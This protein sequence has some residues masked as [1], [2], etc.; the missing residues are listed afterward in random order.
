MLTVDIGKVVS[1]ETELLEGNYVMVVT[2]ILCDSVL[3]ISGLRLSFS[4]GVAYMTAFTVVV[5][6]K[7]GI[8]FGMPI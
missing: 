1:E 4:R 7:L 2:S 3:E 6:L 8:R 5:E